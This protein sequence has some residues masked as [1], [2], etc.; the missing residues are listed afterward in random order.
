VVD[1]KLVH[2]MVDTLALVV[3]ELVDSKLVHMMV[4]KL[5][6]VVA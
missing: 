3:A 1:N 2:T 4:D 6:L 5:A